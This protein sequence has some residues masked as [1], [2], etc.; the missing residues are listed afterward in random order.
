MPRMITTNGR[1]VVIFEG[2]SFNKDDEV[3]VDDDV[4]VDDDDEEDK[5]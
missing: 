1:T 2:S 5:R 3:G 4:V